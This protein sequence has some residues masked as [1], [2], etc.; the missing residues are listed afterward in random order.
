MR[1]VIAAALLAASLAAC[2]SDSPRTRSV[3]LYWDFLR[4]TQTENFVYDAN[5]NVG[6]GD[7]ACFESGVE[8]VQITDEAGQ[9]VNPELPDVPCVFQGVQ[10]VQID[11]VRTGRHVWTLTGYR[12]NVATFATTVTLDVGARSAN[13]FD[14]RLEGIQDDLDVFAVFLDRVGGGFPS[15]VTAGV[16]SL[17]ITL[18]DGIGTTVADVLVPCLDP[19]GASFQVASGTGIDRDSYIVRVKGF[20]SATPAPGTLQIFDS[21]LVPQCQA[22]AFDHLGPQ[23]GPTA[24]VVSVFDVRQ[25]GLCPP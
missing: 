23:I 16:S 4:H 13:T 15:C 22:F 5:V 10:G 1:R 7:A 25:F 8:F 3:V 14:T 24:P 2:G 18:F 19:A 12:G 20:G 6:G 11:L 9:V 21:E 17:A